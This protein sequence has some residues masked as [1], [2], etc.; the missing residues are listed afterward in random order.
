MTDEEFFA[1]ID[2]EAQLLEQF[3]LTDA[4]ERMRACTTL[5]AALTVRVEAAVALHNEVMDALATARTLDR[6]G[7]KQL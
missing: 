7:G 1:M 3:G 5:P 6:L 2:Q 4:A